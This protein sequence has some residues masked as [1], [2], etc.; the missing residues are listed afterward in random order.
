MALQTSHLARCL[1]S[2]EQQPPS[3]AVMTQSRLI[4]P[5]TDGVSDLKVEV[6]L[7]SGSYGKVCP[8]SSSSTV[9]SSLL[10]RPLCCRCSGSSA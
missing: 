8:S 7:G 3:A 6:L 4:L 1:C 5:V 10:K 2:C 9:F